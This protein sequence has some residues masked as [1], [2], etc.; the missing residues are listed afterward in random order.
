MTTAKLCC[1]SFYLTALRI[2]VS[3]PTIDILERTN[4]KFEYEMRG[5]TYLKVKVGLF[6]QCSSMSA[7]LN[8]DTVTKIFTA[9]LMP[10]T[11]MNMWGFFRVKAQKQLTGW[12]VKLVKT[13]I[14][15]LHPQREQKRENP[16]TCSSASEIHSFN[17]V[18]SLPVK[19]SSGSSRTSP[20][21]PWRVWSVAREVPCEGRSCY[22]VRAR[23]TPATRGQRSSLRAAF[24]STCI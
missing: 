7:K 16:F 22:Q 1:F 5:E 18:L 2:H 15:L 3:Q 21:W 19:T 9:T 17:M 12:Q 11:V 10:V 24:P 4:C 8:W 6:I 20:T 13:T 14:F 23:R